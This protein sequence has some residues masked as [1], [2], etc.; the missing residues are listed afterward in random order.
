MIKRYRFRKGLR[1]SITERLSWDINYIFRRSSFAWYSSLFERGRDKLTGE[2]TP[3]YITLD[4]KT[5]KRIYDF[6][7]N[8]KIILT[9][10]DPIDRTYSAIA[11]Q[12]LRPE[13]KRA[14]PLTE[15]GMRKFIN[16]MHTQQ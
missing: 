8:M 13:V 1:K 15:Q 5:V 3:A 6:N 4:K 12:Y 7:P 10:R 14:Q 11:R 9:L 2:I 16:F